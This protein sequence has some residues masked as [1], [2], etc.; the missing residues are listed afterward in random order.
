MLVAMSKR[1]VYTHLS[2]CL[3]ITHFFLWANLSF[4]LQAWLLLI[5]NCLFLCIRPIVS[6]IQ[7]WGTH[8]EELHDDRLV[9]LGEDREPLL[10]GQEETGGKDGTLDRLSK[11]PVNHLLG[12]EV[13]GHLQC[14]KEIRN[15]ERLHGSGHISWSEVCFINLQRN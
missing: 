7:K 9:S 11:P 14:C 2:N 10:V 8:P 13:K 15:K 1:F 3:F 12:W 4:C 5:S 6:H